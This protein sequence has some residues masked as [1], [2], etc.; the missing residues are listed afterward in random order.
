VT[1]LSGAAEVHKLRWLDDHTIRLSV[2]DAGSYAP[3]VVEWARQRD[4]PIEKTEPY[5]PPYDDVFVELVA[6]LDEG[7]EPEPVVANA[8]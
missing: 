3:T 4:V 5:L 8:G 7:S 2:D 6:T 1:S